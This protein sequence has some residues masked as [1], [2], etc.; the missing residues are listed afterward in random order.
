MLKIKNIAQK[1]MPIFGIFEQFKFKQKNQHIT[2]N[3]ALILLKK[4]KDC[5]KI[6]TLTL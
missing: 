4:I 3:G 2:V 6:F 1:I 5:L